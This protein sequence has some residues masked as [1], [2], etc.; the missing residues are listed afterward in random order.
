MNQSL[1]IHIPFCKHRCHYCDFNTYTGKEMLI[2]G[3]V[4][5]LIKELRIDSLI[6]F[7]KS[8]QTIYFGGGTPSLI[9]LQ[10]YKNLFLAIRNLYTLTGDCEISLEANPG[11]ISLDYLNGLREVGFNRISIGVQSTNYIDLQRLA[12]I[13]H[14][15]DVLTSIRN[16]RLVGF[17]NISIDLIFGLPWQDLTSWSNTLSRA[18][19]L[20]PDHLS[21]Y[22]L[23]I[24]PG[25][26]FYNWYQKGLIAKQDE[27][28]EADMY[29]YAIEMLDR[30]GYEHYEISNW[31]KKD[32]QLNYRCQH[33]LQYWLNNSYIGV[34]VGSHGYVEG[35]RTVNIPTISGYIEKMNNDTQDRYGLPLSPAT[36]SFTP[37]DQMTQMKDFMMLGLRLVNEGVSADRFRAKF[38]QS[39]L[40]VFDKEINLL[41][42]KGLIEWVDD[43]SILRLTKMG[44]MV[45][46]QVFMEFV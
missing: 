2:P 7:G 37:V 4:E 6:C 33:N 19:D 9:S 35:V 3:Y 41:I 43:T 27:D 23:I 24:E 1:Y 42:K 32:E 16:A 39:M 40:E 26:Q 8:I 18:I 28:L 29:E 13:H 12:R 11:T 46:N 30:A 20:S 45:G 10:Y 22:S 14:V 5:A 15:E 31:A 17:K 44:V 34:G 25:T 21:L 38:N 36:I